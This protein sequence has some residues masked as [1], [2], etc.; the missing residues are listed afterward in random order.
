MSFISARVLHL[1]YLTVHTMLVLEN[2]I[3]VSNFNT[4]FG[5]RHRRWWWVDWVFL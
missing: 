4:W 2:I 5:G 1:Y 3:M